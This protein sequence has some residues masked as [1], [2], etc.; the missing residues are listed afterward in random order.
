MDESGRKI[1]VLDTNVPLHDSNCL[2]SFQ[3]H[4][5]VIPIP[6]LEE[7]DQ[8]KKGTESI[9]WHAREFVR[10]IEAMSSGK[11][12]NGGADIGPGLGKIFIRSSKELHPELAG[13]FGD[14]K[15]NDHRIIDVAYREQVD[16]K[17][18]GRQVVFVSK[19]VNARMKARALKIVAQ[20]FLSDN[21]DD[22]LPSGICVVEGVD[23]ESIDGLYTGTVPAREFSL[24]EEIQIN[25]YLVLRNGKKSA[26]GVMKAEMGG[27]LI[28]E[29]VDKSPIYGI[30]P[31]N[32]EQTFAAHALM[33]PRV[34]LVALNGKAGT[35]KTLLALASALEQL[36]DYQSILVAR[37]IVPLSNRDIGFLPG[38]V[39]HKIGPYQMPIFDNLGIISRAKNKDKEWIKKIMDA[40]RLVM[41]PLTY[42]RG[43]SLSEIF[44][45]VDE[46]QNLTPHEV[47]TI[48]SRAGEG[49]KIVFTGDVK[50]IDHPYLNE[51]SNGLSYIIG[52]LRGQKLFAHVELVKG[53]RSELA[54]LATN[55]L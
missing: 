51:R 36:D 48:I 15:K 10:Y 25:D 49:T 21:V 14:P 26:L 42:I 30:T 27:T 23:K 3:E 2:F 4:D 39:N 12:L 35:G 29:R 1:F 53:E 6:V 24:S 44:F 47:K 20:D 31:R 37:P 43:R 46:A 33:D 11:M 22:A 9:N 16:E 45:I 17:N 5:I 13:R 8:F 52:K 18:K 41:E 54:E 34:K 19:D 32:A 40:G 7:I 38:E 50:Q 55:F 28:I